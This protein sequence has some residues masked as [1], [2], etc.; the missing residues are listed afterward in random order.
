MTNSEKKKIVIGS[1]RQETNSFSPVI[2]YE[3]GFF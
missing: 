2:T 3:K 1:L